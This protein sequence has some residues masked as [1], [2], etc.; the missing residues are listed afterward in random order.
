MNQHTLN[1]LEFPKIIEEIKKYAISELGIQ[2]IDK[3]KPSNDIDR[4]K[5][6]LAE[7]TEACKILDST[8]SVPLQKLAGIDIILEKLSKQIVLNPYELEAI[9]TLLK[10]TKRLKNFMKER[11]DI[12]PNVSSLAYS[13]YELS[14]VAE[15]INQCIYNGKVDDKASANLEKI[16][17]KM[18][19]AESRMKSKLDT[20]VK[21]TAYKKYLQDTYISIKNNRYVVSVKSEYR[22]N[23]QGIVIDQSS[24]GSTLYIEPAS[25]GKYQVEL[26]T[27]KQDEE[28]E[29]YQILTYL[30]ALVEENLKEMNIN[31]ETMAFYDYLFSKAKYSK[32]INGYEADVNFDGYIKIVKGRHPMI[33]KGCVPLDFEIGKEYKALVITGPNT[34]GKTVVLKSVG[35]FTAMIQSG[36]HVP[37]GKG[38]HFAIYSDILA[39][40]GD[41]QSIEQSLSTFSAHIKNII[42]ILKAASP[43]TLVL[44][45]E[46]GAGT[47]PIEGEGIAVAVLEE[48]YHKQSTIVATS[49]YGK[50][51]NYATNTEG[52]KN[53]KMTFDVGSLKPKY[54]LEIGKAGESNAF[55]IALRLGM[56]QK[57]IEKAHFT[58]YNEVK[59]YSGI[60]KKADIK[61]DQITYKK[62]RRPKSMHREIEKQQSENK[63]NYQIGDNVYVHTLKQHG[64]VYETENKKGE[65]GVMVRDKKMYIPKKRI[66]PFIDAKELYPEDYDFDVIF[67]SKEYRKKSKQMS[68]RHDENLTIEVE[69]DF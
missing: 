38:S 2:L 35:L 46:L 54:I 30:T 61:N 36:L 25:V 18:T 41:G 63:I 62:T 16:R 56:H 45:D 39:D 69:N 59:D 47:D 31:I 26:E 24:T 44:L 37:V 4:I 6:Q 42:G 7:I 22:N 55:I 67:K 52:F 64:I 57:V 5:N 1:L 40:I 9:A 3:I 53:G 21:S 14:F 29:E 33:G 34:G 12:A 11:A 17:K 32:S 13:M 68:K 65:I 28:Q 43:Y 15:E 66:S 48:L 50:I 10:S 51:K 27:L 20:I 19:M 8:A 49:H 60:I 58:T 23:I